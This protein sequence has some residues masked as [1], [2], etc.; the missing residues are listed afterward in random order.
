MRGSA[1]KARSRE[2]RKAFGAEALDALATLDARIGA[3]EGSITTAFN[4]ERTLRY[5]ADTRVTED[6]TRQLR[7]LEQAL[8]AFRTAP[9]YRR[10]WW[11]LTGRA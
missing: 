3:L 1:V 8:T 11:L 10:A 7:A 6:L 9:W 2:I 4:A 5:E